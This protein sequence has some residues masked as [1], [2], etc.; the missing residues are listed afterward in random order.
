MEFRCDKFRSK[1]LSSCGIISMFCD[2]NLPGEN[3][4]QQMHLVPFFGRKVRIALPP[5]AIVRVATS[6][7]QAEHD[8]NEITVDYL[9]NQRSIRSLTSV[10]HC[11]K[12]L[13]LYYWMSKSETCSKNVKTCVPPL[14]M[15]LAYL[16]VTGKAKTGLFIFCLGPETFGL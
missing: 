15:S 5:G 10:W 4:V 3:N 9:I 12:L 6:Y 7:L 1:L 13:L 11:S 2:L 14:E 8:K 16:S